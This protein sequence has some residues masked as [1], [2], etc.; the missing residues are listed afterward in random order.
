MSEIPDTQAFLEAQMSEALSRVRH[1]IANGLT[2]KFE[3]TYEPPDESNVSY[4]GRALVE[5]VGAYVREGS[6]VML[7]WIKDRNFPDQVIDEFSKMLWQRV[8]GE[9]AK[10][11]PDLKWMH[12]EGCFFDSVE[13]LER[14]A[15]FC[16][17]DE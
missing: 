12:L 14:G 11:I 17:G 5:L 2:V 13:D 16:R 10:R 4:G 1:E 8:R 6:I 3:E 7:A 15:F 9:L